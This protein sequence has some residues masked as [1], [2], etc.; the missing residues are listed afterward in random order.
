MDKRIFRVAAASSD[1]YTIDTHYGRATNFYIYQYLTD[2]W[3]FVEKRTL[4]P[5]CLGGDHEPLSM[6]KRAEQLADCQY[7][8]ASRIGIG[9]MAS[10]QQKGIVPMS[11]PGDLMEVLDKIYS[12]NEIQNLFTTHDRD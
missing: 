11:L 9:A 3:I 6:A 10:L 7:V 8:V 4:P 12:Y 1:G 2:E 5:V